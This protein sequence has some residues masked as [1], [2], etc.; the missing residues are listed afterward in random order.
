MLPNVADTARLIRALTSAS[1]ASLA[2]DG[3]TVP[4][5]DRSAPGPRI[6]HIGVGGFHRAHEA[7][8]VDELAA[9]GGNWRICGIGPLAVDRGMAE[10]LHAQDQLYTLIE[11]GGGEPSVRVVGSIIEYRL[12]IEDQRPMVDAIARPET[13]IVSLTITEGGYDPPL[14]SKPSVF[15][16][17]AGAIERR[18]TAGLEPLTVLSCDNILHNGDVARG[19]T[20]T[21]AHRRDAALADWIER[22][23][24]F[25]NSMVDRITPATTD[26]DRAWLREAHGID[27]RWPVVAESFRQWVVEDRFASGRPQLEDVGVVFT[28]RVGDWEAYKLRMLNATHTILAYVAALAGIRLVDE[29]LAVP[30][31]NRFARTFLKDEVLPALDVDIPGHPAGA[32]ADSVLDRFARPGIR[33]QIARLCIDGTVKFPTFV[34]PTVTAQLGVGGPIRA[35]VTS[36]AAWARYLAVVPVAEQA[37]DT[38]AD[39]AREHAMRAVRDPLRFLDFRRVFPDRVAG[40]SRFRDEFVTQLASLRDDGPL[41]TVAAF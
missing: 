16:G 30:A 1:L 40:D 3:L 27:D 29:A 26:P 8:Y 9:A 28:D 6:V 14:S 10:A 17:L 7:L 23:C 18:V 41:T 31:L 25:P 22:N 35:S 32:Y 38:F 13:S 21:A 34:I 37:H 12:A 36:L 33:D 4:T 20:I 2:A 11:H 24:T 15:D 19:A 5:Y 39:E